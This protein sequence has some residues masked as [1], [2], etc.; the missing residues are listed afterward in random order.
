[1]KLLAGRG[2]LFDSDEESVSGCSGFG[3]DE[4]INWMRS[5]GFRNALDRKAY[6]G[7]V[8]ILCGIEREDLAMKVF[9]MMKGYGHALGIKTYDLLIGKLAEHNQIIGQMHCLR[10]WRRGECQWLRRFIS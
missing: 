5:A 2:D 3:G 10:R 1:M 9:R 8:K 7:F 4:M 6:Y